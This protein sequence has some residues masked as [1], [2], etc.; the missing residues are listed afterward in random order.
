MARPPT[1]CS[2]EI[3]C[4]FVQAA[5]LP[6]DF[7]KA[8]LNHNDKGVTGAYARWNMFEEKREAAMAIEATTLPL[9][10]QQIAHQ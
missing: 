3:R 5:R 7:V 8:L 6:I 4:T 1:S 9:I 2:T 10:P